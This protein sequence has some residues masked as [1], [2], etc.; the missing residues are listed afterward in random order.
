MCD[1]LLCDDELF[2]IDLIYLIK[3]D[4]GNGNF[5]HKRLCYQSFF[6]VRFNE[7]GPVIC[8]WLA[9]EPVVLCNDP[10]IIKVR[11]LQNLFIIENFL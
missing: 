4:N 1:E 7:F 9:I 6:I 2:F 11:M 8:V 3:F 10:V 5:S